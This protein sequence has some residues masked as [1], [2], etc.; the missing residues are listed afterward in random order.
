MA[1]SIRVVGFE[2]GKYQRWRTN[3]SVI[4][5]YIFIEILLQNCMNIKTIAIE[6]IKHTEGIRAQITMFFNLRNRIS[7]LC[8]YKLKNNLKINTRNI[9]STKFR[10]FYDISLE[11]GGRGLRP[12]CFNN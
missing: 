7:V 5:T 8:V 4:Y 9:G 11:A 10:I 1:S 6:H 12:A 3:L 2:G